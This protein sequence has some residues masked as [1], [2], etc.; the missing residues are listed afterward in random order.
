MSFRKWYLASKYAA[1]AHPPAAMAAVVA[2][3]AQCQQQ[4]LDFGGRRMLPSAMAQSIANLP[5][6]IETGHPMRRD[7]LE[8]KSKPEKMGTHDSQTD[9]RE[10]T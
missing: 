5:Y 8:G 3:K 4:V 6:P 9:S 1:A 2:I 7:D 10:Y